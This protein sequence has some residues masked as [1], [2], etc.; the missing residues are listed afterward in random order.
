MGYDTA[1]GH[2]EGIADTDDRLLIQKDGL[3]EV[4]GQLTVGAT[5][6][7]T[8]YSGG[9][10]WALAADVFIVGFLTID[11]A[12]FAMSVFQIPTDNHT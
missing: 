8:T 5:V 7:A 1:Q 9:K 4:V 2:V 12:F 10:R 3:D 6:T 11:S